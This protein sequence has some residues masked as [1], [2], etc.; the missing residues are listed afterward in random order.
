MSFSVYLINN[1]KVLDIVH[2]SNLK[3]VIHFWTVSTFKSRRINVKV[4][5]IVHG[6][7]TSMWKL[8]NKIPYPIKKLWD[9]EL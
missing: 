9:S 4:W 5:I 6:I 7:Q 3:L 8:R 2:N 1:N